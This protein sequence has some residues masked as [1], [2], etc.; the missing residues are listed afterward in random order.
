MKVTTSIR[1]QIDGSS[2]K[3]ISSLETKCV[4]S[5]EIF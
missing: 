4:Y 5:Y 1:Q 3:R 2:F